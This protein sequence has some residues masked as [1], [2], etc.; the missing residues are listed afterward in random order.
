MVRDAA[1]EYAQ[2]SLAPRVLEAFRQEHTDPSIF[3]EMGGLGLL[4]TTIP[5]E[6]R[7]R[8]SQLRQLRAHRARSRARGF[9]IPIHD[10]R[11]VLAGH[12]AHS[13]VRQ[14]GAKAPLSA[15][16]RARRIDRLLRP[17]RTQS[18]LGSGQHGD[19]RARRERRV[20]LERDPRPGFPTAPF[21][22]VFVVWAKTDDDAIRGFILEKGW[23]G[24]SAPPLRGKV[25]L[26]AST[27]G[28]IVMDDVFVPQENLLPGVSG[29]KGPF[30]CLDSARY[31]ISWGALGAAES[32]WHTARELCAR[33][34]TIRPSARRQS[35]D[36]KETR[37]HANRDHAG[38]AGLPAA[39]AHEGRGHR[40]RG[41]H[42]HAEAQFLRQGA[43][44]R[45]RRARHA[46]RKR[47]IRTNS[48]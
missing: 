20:S 22:D 48:A 37:R 47:H 38:A 8:R 5:E 9:G 25:G 41:N 12:A 43:R 40:R 26:R 32:C 3:R 27:T 15:A 4:G 44:C 39:R 13:C 28:Q 45:A 16:A 24:L 33:T 1:R 19:A 6:Y 23:K 11:A 7:R 34:Q 30:T 2:G 18:R 17:D 14:R 29:L 10:E 46:G 31:G 36:S 35:A 42:L 21:A